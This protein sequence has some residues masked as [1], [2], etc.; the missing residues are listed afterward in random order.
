MLIQ[1]HCRVLLALAI[2]I[3]GPSRATAEKVTFDEAISIAAKAPSVLPPAHELEVRKAKDQALPSNRGP[4]TIRLAPGRRFFPSEEA[5]TEVSVGIMQG[6]NLGDLAGRSRKAARAERAV[7][8]ARV[9]ARMLASKIDVAGRWFQLFE[10]ES[11]LV[12]ARDE[13]AV[14]A[15]LDRANARAKK[16]GL[17]TSV[18]EAEAKAALA[19]ARRLERF[20]EG[21]RV[22]AALALSVAMGGE[23]D[24]GLRAQGPLPEPRLP[25]PAEIA[26][27]AKRVE[28]L[29]QVALLRLQSTAASARAAESRAGNGR[30]LG[31]G[32]SAQ[33]ESTG[34]TLVFGNL[35]LS[36]SGA[37]TGQRQQA[38]SH[39]LA[40]RQLLEA[41]RVA[42]GLRAEMAGAVH[43]LEHSE[44]VWTLVFNELQP[45]SEELLR[46]RSRE[47]ELGE[48]TVIEVLRARARLL[49]AKRL[50]VEADVER[51][52]AQVH[53]WLLLAEI[54]VADAE[55]EAK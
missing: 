33:R 2:V 39:A 8:A 20:L 41:D 16:A 54:L 17:T 52:W 21:E 26:K 25:S 1:I 36:F 14:I 45:A 7:L 46:R 37:N 10:A 31:F 3:V 11:V 13:L 28:Q 6:W 44:E 24:A 43:E 34:S 23:P 38:K 12:L 30:R 49:S 5:G 27:L 55:G 53:I 19:E 15:D 18:A 35:Q 51:R 9:R 42:K 22:K 32:V 4:L 29:P 50:A 40:R 47:L 48:G